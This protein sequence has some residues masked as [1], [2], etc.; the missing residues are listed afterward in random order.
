MPHGFKAAKTLALI[1]P[2]YLNKLTELTFFPFFMSEVQCTGNFVM[3][4]DC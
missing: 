3:R 1:N 4:S 2:H